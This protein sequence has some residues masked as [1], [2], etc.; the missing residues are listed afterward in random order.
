MEPRLR[1]RHVAVTVLV[2]AQEYDPT[3]DR[4]VAELVR[5][6]VPLFR[7]N[8]AW[9][10]QRMSLG[11]QLRDGRWRGLLRTE[12]R[13]IE[14]VDIRSVLYRRPTSFVF[15][16]TL[17]GPEQRHATWEAKLGLGGILADIDALWVNHPTATADAAYKPVQLATAER[18]GFTVP[19]TLI[20]NRPDDVRVFVAEHK[21]VVVKTLAF[22]AIFEDGGGK[23]L[24]TH[25]LTAKD[26]EDLTGVGT[27]AHLF[28]TFISD[29]A[30]EARVTVVGERQYDRIIATCAVQRI[31]RAWITQLARGGRLVVPLGWGGAL[32]VLDKISDTEVTGRVDRAE[33][34]FMRL[35]RAADEPMPARIAPGM[36]STAPRLAHHGLTDVDPKI[37]DDAAFRL[38][39]ALHRPDLLITQ[40]CQD[41][42]PITSIVYDQHER[43]AASR[44]E[45]A[46]GLWPVLQRPA[47]GLGGDRVALLRAHRAPATRPARAHRPH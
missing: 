35:R 5:R 15:P 37:L 21:Q 23:V 20:T 47:V 8:L 28:Q 4:I 36:P 18:C 6:A 3:V 41:G 32:A 30:F 29:K 13:D 34:R 38:W 1:G 44:T 46:V 14:L 45:A 7:A 17:S 33:I 12:H 42:V 2:L 24:Y 25:A 10:P 26:L 39:L 16:E 40:E 9:F 22:G 43:A 19:P 31:P 11:A 27:T